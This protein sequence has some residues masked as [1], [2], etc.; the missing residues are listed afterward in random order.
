VNFAGDLIFN[1]KQG[2]NINEKEKS[3]ETCYDKR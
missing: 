1:G 2:D 3:E